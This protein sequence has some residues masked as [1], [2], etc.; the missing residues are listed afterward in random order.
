MNRTVPRLQRIDKIPIGTSSTP[1]TVRE[2]DDELR[3]LN[4]QYQIKTT[5]PLNVYESEPKKYIPSIKLTPDH[6]K[7]QYSPY[8]TSFTLRNEFNP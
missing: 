5:K 6:L 2:I 4:E 7:T 8:P 1:M 3:K